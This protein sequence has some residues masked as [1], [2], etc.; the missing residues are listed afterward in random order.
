MCAA[1]GREFSYELLAAMSGLRD[2]ELRTAMD[3]LQ[4]A[5]LIFGHRRRQH[6]LSSMRSSATRRTI[7]CCR[8]VL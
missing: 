2:V 6:I 4:S 1:L 8:D 3:Q 5:E 7:P